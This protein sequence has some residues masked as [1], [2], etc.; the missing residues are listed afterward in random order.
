[1][2]LLLLWIVQY[3]KKVF[4]RRFGYVVQNTDILQLN[5]NLRY[6]A[7][8]NVE[9]SVRAKPCRLSRADP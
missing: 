5:M 7:V 9:H 2:T 3:V 4:L 8:V 6:D 1:M